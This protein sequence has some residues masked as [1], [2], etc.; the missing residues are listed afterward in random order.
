MAK[1][2]ALA[3]VGSESLMGRELR[4]VVFSAGLGRELRLIAGQED[5]GVLTE[6]EGE[7]AF[8]AVL[9]AESLAGARIVFLAGSAGSARKALATGAGAVFIDLVHAAEDVP[10]ARLRAPMV[11][12]PD[13][14]APRG[15]VQVVAH[16]AAIA[17]ALALG[18]I[19]DVH[20]IRRSVVHVFEPA[21]ERGRAGVEELQHQTVNLL[22]FKSLP[23]AVYD[24]Q[25][26]FNLLSRYGQEAPFAL[27][28]AEA[29]LERHL[30]TL[31]AKAENPIPM[32]SLRLIQ[33]PVFHGHSFSFWIEFEE[34][35]GAAE[36]EAVLS[37]ANIDVRGA[38]TDPPTAVGMVGQSGIAVGAVS[39]DRNEPDACWF[40]VAAD[41]LR[42][43]AENALAV[44]LEFL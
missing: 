36:I 3:L 41:N 21:S 31:L 9:D 5:A 24:E 29:R 33:A 8:A 1:P 40:W 32:P 2:G 37:V 11:E 12:P 7:A 34:N 44:A 18:R 22:S 30:A 39:V 10:E 17:I 25:L 19:N 4:D 23:K 6:E 20:P 15:A 13:H 26:G 43:A 35:P 14:A 16:P 27:E 42:L 38:G 28:E